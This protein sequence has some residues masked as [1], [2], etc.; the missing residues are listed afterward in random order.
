MNI[1][2][3]KIWWL[4]MFW[5]FCW[6]S[7]AVYICQMDL[8]IGLSQRMGEFSPRYMGEDNLMWMQAVILTGNASLDFEFSYFTPLRCSYS[9]LII[10]V[11]GWINTLAIYWIS[12]RI[13][14]TLWSCIRRTQS[15]QVLLF[16][17]KKL[18]S[19]FFQCELLPSLGV[20]G[21]QVLRQ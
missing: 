21:I 16:P 19:D 20:R 3:I 12:W 14:W 17:P 11:I 9:L 8:L 5:W 10:C 18:N 1:H 4:P 13:S 7:F 2:Q 6:Q 15:V